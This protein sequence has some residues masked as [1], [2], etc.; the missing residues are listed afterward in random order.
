MFEN[1]KALMKMRSLVRNGSCV[2]G[3]DRQ[4]NHVSINIFI[5]ELF[6][7]LPP[8]FLILLLSKMY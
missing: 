2:L 5:K 3:P 1:S 4:I 7:L 8:V 6:A